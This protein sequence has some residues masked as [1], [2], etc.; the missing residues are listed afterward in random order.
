MAYK[1]QYV[2]IGNPKAPSAYKS[3]VKAPAAYKP[4]K[5]NVK[6]YTPGSYKSQYQGQLNDAMKTV[7]D[8]KYDP[9]QD[10][11]Y[12]ALAKVYGERGNR[13]AKNTLADAASLNG[14]MQ[15]SYAVSAAQ[16]ARNQYNQELAALVPELER[17]AYDRATSTYNILKGAD[18]TAYG[19]FRDT[20]ADRQWKYSQDYQAYRDREADNQWRY[21]QNY[22]AYRDRETDSQ[23]AYSQ[24]YDRYKDSLAQYQWGQNFNSDLYFKLLA[25]ELSG[26]SGGGGGG[27]GRSGGG[28][29]SGGGGYGGGG[30]AG[31]SDWLRELYNEGSKGSGGGSSGGSSFSLPNRKTA[32]ETYHKN[33]S[34]NNAQQRARA[35]VAN[36]N[37]RGR[38][39]KR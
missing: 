17:T 10:A 29:S 15:T 14:G 32:Y 22:Q 24:M 21:S 26:G 7:T 31:G 18:D 27:G 39:R 12:Q 2:T 11:S 3:N 8:W 38:N 33:K 9:L 20:E 1:P 30:S 19:R 25:E 16:Q 35:N 5:N 36:D 13:A 34:S 23:W 6:A 4:V 37:L 28:R